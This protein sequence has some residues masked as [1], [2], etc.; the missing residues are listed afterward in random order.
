LD[1]DQDTGETIP[2]DRANRQRILGTNVDLGA[3]EGGYTTFARTHPGLDPDTDDNSNGLSNYTDYALGNDPLAPAGPIKPF[4]L[5]LENEF[6]IIELTIRGNGIDTT[7]TLEATQ[8]LNNWYPASSNDADLIG[9]SW[10]SGDSTVRV[11]H[12]ELFRRGYS[13]QKFFRLR[14]DPPAQVLP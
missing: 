8:N 2:L 14:I 11:L 6:P 7:T 4:H 5:N 3:F 1:A 10:P 12:Y 13:S 9:S